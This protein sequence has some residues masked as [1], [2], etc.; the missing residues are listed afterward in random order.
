MMRFV[1]LGSFPDGQ[2]ALVI[3]LLPRSCCLLSSRSVDG[4]FL[5]KTVPGHPSLL[6][7]R[8]LL[9]SASLGKGS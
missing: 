9:H 4:H 8:D 2:Y 3:E 6:R 5:P 7:R 1:Y